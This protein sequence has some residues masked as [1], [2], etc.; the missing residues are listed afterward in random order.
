[1]TRADLI[2]MHE[3]AVEVSEASGGAVDALARTIERICRQQEWEAGHAYLLRRHPSPQLRPSPALWRC[4]RPAAFRRFRRLTSDSGFDLGQGMI[5]NVA[6]GRRAV[7]IENVPAASPPVRFGEFGNEARSG[8]IIPVVIRPESRTVAVAE[9]YSSRRRRINSA[10]L[11]LASGIGA[12]LG[13]VFERERA[14]K[15]LAQS[16]EAEQQRIGR[17]LHDTVSQELAGITM[18]AERLGERLQQAGSPNSEIALEL[19]HHLAQV[20][21]K[22]HAMSRGLLPVEI[23]S[24]QLVSAIEYLAKSA[25]QLHGLDCQVHCD[26]EVVVE[27]RTVANHLARIAQEAIQNTVKHARAR[28][29]RI[30]LVTRER[31]I[32]LSVADDGIGFRRDRV[33]V[34]I[35]TRLMH[36]RAEAI[37]AELKLISRVGRG[38]L[39]RCEWAP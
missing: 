1:V 32:V 10:R 4:T 5:G 8:L 34:G 9:F 3:I 12:L 38:T 16:R 39:V 24:D 18:L 27:N 19:A 26:E 25:R 33:P 23:E 36:A 14:T 15:Q 31:R 17:E 2:L 30:R 11:W 37:G 22:V 35:G 13:R 6:A 20:R 29:V 7:W 21:S 28:Q